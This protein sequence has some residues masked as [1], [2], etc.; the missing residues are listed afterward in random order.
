MIAKKR[1]AAPVVMISICTAAFA[2]TLALADSVTARPVQPASAAPAAAPAIAPKVDAIGTLPDLTSAILAKVNTTGLTVDLLSATDQL[3]ISGTLLSLTS[4]VSDLI[5]AFNVTGEGSIVAGSLA[6]VSTPG[7]GTDVLGANPNAAPAVVPS[8]V[9]R[10][11]WVF[12]LKDQQYLTRVPVTIGD[13]EDP[14]TAGPAPQP[15]DTFNADTLVVLD[16]IT[17]EF[18]QSTTLDTSQ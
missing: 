6:L 8:L 7:I 11:A 5:D 15:S 2:T 18:L 14:E 16:A 1:L 17:G 13:N 4:A 10:P 3:N 9:L 12:L